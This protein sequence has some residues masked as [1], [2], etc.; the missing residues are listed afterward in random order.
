MP[1]NVPAAKPRRRESAGQPATAG[2]GAAQR[3][4]MTRRG[5]G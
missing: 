4:E 5:Q 2:D 1:A 3:R